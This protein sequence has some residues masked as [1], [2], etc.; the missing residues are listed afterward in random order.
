MNN[1][2]V[3]RPDGGDFVTQANLWTQDFIPAPSNVSWNAEN[4]LFSFFFGINDVA[5][6]FQRDGNQTAIHE[7]ILDSYIKNLE[8]LYENGSKNWLF[9]N[10]VPFDKIKYGEFLSPEDQ[11]KLGPAILDYNQVLDAR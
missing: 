11:K 6:T 5:A 1:T 9:L 7:E 3:N 8:I 10:V 4:S 2:I